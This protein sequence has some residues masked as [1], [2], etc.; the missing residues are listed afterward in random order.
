MAE[1]Q[2]GAAGASMAK[3]TFQSL[4][5]R[6]RSGGAENWLAAQWRISGGVA[7]WPG[8]NKGVA[9]THRRQLAASH[10]RSRAA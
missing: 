10:R 4:R 6:S 8:G 2:P 3:E 9:I 7:Y 1:N 5:Q